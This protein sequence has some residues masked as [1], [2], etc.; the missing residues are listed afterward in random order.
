MH[1]MYEVLGLGPKFSQINATK[2]NIP[3]LIAQSMVNTLKCVYLIS[4]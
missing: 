2:I 1:I 3:N 4:F